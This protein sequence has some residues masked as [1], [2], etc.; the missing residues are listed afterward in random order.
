M[1]D[2]SRKETYIVRMN[3]LLD[4]SAVMAIILNEPN[5]DKVI[6]LTKNTIILAPEVISFEIGNALVNLFRRSKITGEELL[7]AYRNYM[8][9]PLRTVKVDIVKALKIACKYKIYA[10]D[11][12]YLEIAY[13]QKLSLV[14]FDESMKKV[15]ENL[16]ITINQNT[17]EEH[18]VN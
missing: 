7:E 16:K 9:I 17:S 8:L 14:T 18:I 1:L 3:I 15:G 12:Y 11:A 13:R 6:K 2:K 10:Y 4:A 5:R